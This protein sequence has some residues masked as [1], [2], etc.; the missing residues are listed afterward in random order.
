MIDREPLVTILTPVYNGGP[1][2]AECIES[3]LRQTY[4][5]W[6]YVIVDNCSTDET[7]A[8]A[9]A[10]AARDQR[11]RV[12]TNTRFVN[13]AENHNNAF[14]CVG[15]ASAYTKVVS[16][17]D[18]LL[19][20]C[21]ERLVARARSRP[22]IGVV[23][24]Y[25]QSGQQVHWTAMP[26]DREFVTGR[27]AARML[28]LENLCIFGPP[29]AMLYRSDLVRARSSFFPHTRSHADI[30]V[31]YE[32]LRTSDYGFVHEVLSEERLHPGQESAKL[33]DL[34]V[35]DVAYLDDFVTYGAYF[36]SPAEV[37]A[38]KK[39]LFDMH[40]RTLARFLLRL[41]GPKFWRYQRLRMREIGHP[42]EWGRLVK[43][44]LGEA[45]TEMRHPRA[46]MRKLFR[47]RREDPAPESR[48]APGGIADR[49]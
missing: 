17:D 39:Q 8:I 46:A 13:A 6:E 24:S 33:D 45:S 19:P 35:N 44:A 36:L 5:R 23:G 30:S 41:R 42:M 49:G 47:G 37:A 22:S 18:W 28:L 15:A 31:C 34:S 26:A 32:C 29:T 16:A 1:F 12:V 48:R 20:N 7:P 38:R 21:V 25:Q 4:S 43:V 9:R 10:Y 27:E 11:I 40:Y 3:V 2:L 14:R